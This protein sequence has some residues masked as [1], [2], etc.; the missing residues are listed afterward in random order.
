MASF[1]VCAER[2]CAIKRRGIKNDLFI[3]K[4]AMVKES[5]W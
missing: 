1:S 3:V 2:D 5:L 4:K